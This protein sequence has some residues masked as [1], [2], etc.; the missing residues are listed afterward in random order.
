MHVGSHGMLLSD[1]L[2][3]LLR[4]L[5]YFFVQFGHLQVIVDVVGLLERLGRHDRNYSIHSDEEVVFSPSPLSELVFCEARVKNLLRNE[6]LILM[7]HLLPL[8]LEGLARL[9]LRRWLLVSHA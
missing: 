5:L 8:L 3:D 6:W 4:S 2:L 1:E 7:R 9:L